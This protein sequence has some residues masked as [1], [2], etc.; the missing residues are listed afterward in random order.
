MTGNGHVLCARYRPYEV[1]T[2]AT[3]VSLDAGTIGVQHKTCFCMTKSKYP[4]MP[5]AW[6]NSQ[7][8]GHIAV[9]QMKASF[10]AWDQER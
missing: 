4:H 1:A 8:H 10:R 7:C 3:D 9:R 6:P 5:E 2:T